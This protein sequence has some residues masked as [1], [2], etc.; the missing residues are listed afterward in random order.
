MAGQEAQGLLAVWTDIAPEA[1]AEFNE[2]YNTE[3]IP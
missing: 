2:W 1:E 3:H